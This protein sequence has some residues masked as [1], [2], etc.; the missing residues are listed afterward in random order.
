[1][2]KKKVFVIS[3]FTKFN[4]FY[5]DK[6]DPNSFCAIGTACVS[7]STVLLHSSLLFN[8]SYIPENISGTIRLSPAFPLSFLMSVPVFQLYDLKESIFSV[9]IS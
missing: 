9:L 4:F 5:Q 3:W 1:M 6:V 2:A 7:S 8:T